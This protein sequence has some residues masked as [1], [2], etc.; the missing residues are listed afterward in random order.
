MKESWRKHSSKWLFGVASIVFLLFIG[1]VLPAE[2]DE[3]RHRDWVER[4]A[5][6]ELR[7]FPRHLARYRGILWRSRAILLHRLKIVV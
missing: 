1:L 4:V 3:I 5:R 2:S 6:L 7:V